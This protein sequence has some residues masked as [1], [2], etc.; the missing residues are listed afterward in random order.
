MVDATREKSFADRLNAN[1][2]TEVI[3][4]VFTVGAKSDLYKTFDK[5]LSSG[6]AKLPASEKAKGTVEYE[7]CVQQLADLQKNWR[8]TNLLVSHPETRGAHDDYCL[9]TDT[10]ILTTRGFLKYDE[11]QSD[12]LVAKVVNNEIYY[13]KPNKVIYKDYKGYMYRFSSKD[14]CLEV[15]E[16]HKMLTRKPK[17]G[18]EVEMTSQELYLIPEETR[19]NTVSIPVAPIQNLKDLY[20][21]D[22]LIQ[23]IAWF[24]TEVGLISLVNTILIDIVFHNLFI[25]LLIIVLNLW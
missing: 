20:I 3:P 24:I 4:Y 12:D 9:S 6:R 16:N 8:G 11:L 17:T 23:Q 21:S 14:L 25:I 10:E 13:V 15:T 2:S 1:V 19:Y 5:E 18:R 22:D 7:K